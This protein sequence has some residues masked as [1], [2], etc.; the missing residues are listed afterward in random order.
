MKNLTDL[1]RRRSSEPVLVCYNSGQFLS[2][3]KR[4]R[5]LSWCRGLQSGKLNRLW[6][7]SMNISC[8]H[9]KLGFLFISMA[10]F[11][12]NHPKIYRYYEILAAPYALNP[13]H[14]GHTFC[15]LCILKWFFPAYIALAGVGMN[16]L[17]VLSVTVSWWPHQ[18]VLFEDWL[19]SHLFQSG[20]LLQPL[21]PSSR[22]SLSYHCAR[23]R[24]SKRKKQKACGHHNRERIATLNVLRRNNRMTRN[25]TRCR[26]CWM[27]DFGE[28]VGIWEWSGLK[29]I[30]QSIGRRKYS[31]RH[32]WQWLLFWSRHATSPTHGDNATLCW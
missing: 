22:S 20:L 24:K 19:P 30:G 23:K 26:T 21:S 16:L 12:S 1:S 2:Q 18:K 27:W 31:F 15:A 11:L 32:V 13:G 28:R 29:G 8:V 4:M 7:N 25:P 5:L 3:G 10:R 6:D 9:C 17:I 14:Y